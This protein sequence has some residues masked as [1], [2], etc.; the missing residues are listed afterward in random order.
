MP[1]PQPKF[2]E[3]DLHRRTRSVGIPPS[4][5]SSHDVS[6]SSFTEPAQIRPTI[7]KPSPYRNPVLDA[8]APRVTNE[9][10]QRLASSS[11]TGVD[12][13]DLRPAPSKQQVPCGNRAAPQNGARPLHTDRT[14]PH[15]MQL[16]QQGSS[17]SAPRQFDRR[18]VAPTSL[19]ASDSDD[20][21]FNDE[22]NAAL[23][24]I[25]D[26]AMYGVESSDALAA[27][28]DS[29]QGRVGSAGR[30]VTSESSRG[31]GA[32]PQ[33]ATSVNCYQPTTRDCSTDKDCRCQ[34]AVIKSP[35]LRTNPCQTF[36]EP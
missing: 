30:D 14:L 33:A 20:I 5:G 6:S 8:K 15:Q 26:S 12:T 18:S 17:T 2:D 29:A 34:L 32:R 7:S 9:N 3:S 4:A 10:G 16:L 31:V 13:T 25:E 27:T 22:D 1:S 19:K 23:L 35:R 21:Y 28:R 11:R 36:A 24:A